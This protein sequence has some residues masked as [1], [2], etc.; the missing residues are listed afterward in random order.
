LPAQSICLFGPSQGGEE[1]LDNLC[2]RSIRFSLKLTRCGH[3]GQRFLQVD[4]PNPK[5]I[6]LLLG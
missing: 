1:M 3:P 5:L 6:S 2:T 4:D